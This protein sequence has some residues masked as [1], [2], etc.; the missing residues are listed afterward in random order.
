MR[1]V[2]PAF[3]AAALLVG[4]ASAQQPQ[5]DP[6]STVLRLTET[7]EKMVRRDRLRA[8]LRVEASGPDARRVQ[9][10]VNRRM[11][12]ALDRA[13]AV[14]SVR[15]E[16]GASSIWEERPKNAP[17]RWHAVQSIILSGKDAPE[18]LTLV[19]ELQGDGLLISSLGYELTPEAARSVEDELTQLA[20]E[21]LRQ[22]AE[23]IAK[24]MGHSL[25]RWREL[26]VGNTGGA[27]P[28]RPPVPMR[29]AMSAETT[30]APVAEP[31][32][33]IVRVSVEGDALLEPADSR[34][35]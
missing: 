4:A 15:P 31:G 6:N 22:R 9:S 5:S 10:D 32:E 29:A 8:E 17:V 28:P 2:F 34:P 18:L 20:L 12:A 27:P 30:Q 14:S 26:R 7:A 25:A 19:G 21:R 1:V 11:S 16:T 23:K 3:L 13:R 24:S 35:P 33:T